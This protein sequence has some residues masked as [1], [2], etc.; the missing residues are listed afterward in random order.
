MHNRRGGGSLGRSTCRR[1]RVRGG[2]HRNGSRAAGGNGEGRAAVARVDGVVEGADGVAGRGAGFVTGCEG[3]DADGGDA[4]QTG[5]G[6]GVLVFFFSG[7]GEE[8]GGVL[9]V[10]V[11]GFGA[12]LEEGVGLG[13]FGREGERRGLTALQ[14]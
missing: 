3:L 6:G 1:R 5:E 4:G 12:A 10:T 2:R 7:G 11:A 8:G 13:G 14:R 9:V